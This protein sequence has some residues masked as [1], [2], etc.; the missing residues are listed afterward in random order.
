[1]APRGLDA[2]RLWFS[3]LTEP[4][5]TQQVSNHLGTDLASRDGQVMAL[6]ECAGWLEFAGDSEP[7]TAPARAEAARL[8]NALTA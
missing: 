8:I 7:L 2:A 1:M 4:A 6:W 5:L 3:S